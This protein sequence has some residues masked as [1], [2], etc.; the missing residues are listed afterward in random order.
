MYYECGVCATSV[1]PPKY[2]ALYSVV[3]NWEM[4]P[5]T[6][7]PAWPSMM[8]PDSTKPCAVPRGPVYPFKEKVSPGEITA[9][10][11]IWAVNSILRP[12][13]SEY[14]EVLKSPTTSSNDAFSASSV[15]NSAGSSSAAASDFRGSS[16]GARLLNSR[17]VVPQ[18]TT[19]PSECEVTRTHPPTK[20]RFA[21]C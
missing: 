7:V 9:P 17:K 21:L 6:A 14:P 3:A 16:P 2:A 1:M 15:G 11:T 10:L 8:M 20:E 19:S 13:S 4:P 12:D 18:S 5:P